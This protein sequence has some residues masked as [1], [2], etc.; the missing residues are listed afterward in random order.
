M[1]LFRLRYIVSQIIDGIARRK[2]VFV[3][4][5]TDENGKPV[6]DEKGFVEMLAADGKPL[7]ASLLLGP[8]ADG[9]GLSV[10]TIH[11]GGTNKVVEGF[12]LSEPGQFASATLPDGTPSTIAKT[13]PGYHAYV[14]GVAVLRMKDG[15]PVIDRNGRQVLNIEDPQWELWQSASGT[16]SIPLKQAAAAPAPVP[17]A[18][19]E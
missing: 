1:N 15:Q 3:A 5:K 4:I 2:A 18:D 19:V 6:R 14:R 7:V 10:A 12:V 16:F 8:W 11:R 13:V 17:V 9:T